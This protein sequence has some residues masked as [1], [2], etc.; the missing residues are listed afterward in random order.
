MNNKRERQ[1]NYQLFLSRSGPSAFFLL[2]SGY[3]LLKRGGEGRGKVWQEKRA[4]FQKRK[5]EV[6]VIDTATSAAGRRGG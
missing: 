6:S 2:T 3:V 5:G 4:E 1:S